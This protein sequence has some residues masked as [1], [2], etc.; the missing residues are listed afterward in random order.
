[1]ATTCKHLGRYSSSGT[2]Q[3]CCKPG[4]PGPAGAPG[5]IGPR[6]ESFTGFTGPTGAP[7]D[8]YN[9]T[10]TTPMT[11][12]PVLGGSINAMYVAT[13]LAYISGNT[14][15]VVDRSSSYSFIALVTSYDPLTGKLSLHDIS[16]IHPVCSTF[17]TYYYNVN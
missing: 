12:T 7:A 17:P 11:L 8:K 10:T 5:P 4:L 9:T 1:M 13:G 14:V 16:N 2:C 6:G 15:L 3:A